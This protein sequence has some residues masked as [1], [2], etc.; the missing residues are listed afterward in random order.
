LWRPGDRLI[1]WFDIALAQDRLPGPYRLWI[2][3]YVHTPPD[4]FAAVQVLDEAGR[5][6]APGVEWP[7][8]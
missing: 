3:M 4:Q 6:L 7:V 5:P 8:R 2:G 1:S